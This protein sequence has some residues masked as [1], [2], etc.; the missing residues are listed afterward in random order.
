MCIKLFSLD[1]IQVPRL[2]SHV[3]RD[4]IK[5]DGQTLSMCSYHSMHATFHRADKMEQSLHT[6]T[7]VQERQW[8]TVGRYCSLALEFHRQQGKEEKERRLGTY[9]FFQVSQTLF[10]ALKHTA[11]AQKYRCIQISFISGNTHVAVD[12]ILPGFSCICKS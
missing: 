10:K 2:L 11:V 3:A 5:E 7:F 12:F 9:M 1:R 4:V 6:F 8:S